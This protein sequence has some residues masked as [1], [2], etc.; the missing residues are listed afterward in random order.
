[1][2]TALKMVHLFLLSVFCPLTKPQTTPL[3]YPHALICLI[4]ILCGITSNTS[5]HNDIYFVLSSLEYFLCCT[6]QAVSLLPRC[7]VKTARGFDTHSFSLTGVQEDVSS[8]SKQALPLHLISAERWQETMREARSSQVTVLTHP[9]RGWSQAGCKQVCYPGP[10]GGCPLR[11]S[12]WHLLLVVAAVL[13][14]I[15]WGLAEL[16][17]V[18]TA[19]MTA[20]K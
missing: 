8:F 7:L 11:F 15:K 13:S 9:A 18:A 19:T 6:I 20:F 5:I 2:V 12:M 1:M 17:G 14:E 10:A 3:Y 4:N 16:L